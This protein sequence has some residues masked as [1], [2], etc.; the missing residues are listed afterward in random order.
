MNNYFI[1]HNEF[2]LESG[3]AL[4]GIKIAYT[5]SGNPFAK[6]TIWVC[7]ALSG[8]AEATQWWAGLFSDS[9]LF[10]LSKYRV[11]CANVLGS[12]YGSTGAG[13]LEEPLTFP[14]ITIRDMV[15]AHQLLAAYLNV[16]NVDVLIGASLGGQQALEWS[17]IDTEFADQLILVATNAVHSP[18]GIA[19]NESQRLALQADLTFGLK[20][21]G[22]AGLKAARAIAMLSYRSAND[23]TIKQSDSSRSAFSHRASSYVNYQG[24]KFIDRFNPYAYFYLSKAMDSHDVSRSRS[25]FSEVLSAVKAKTL[26][27]GVDSDLLFPLTEQ[28]FLA[29]HITGAELG[30]IKSPYGHDAFLIEFEQLNELIK[31]FLYNDFKR[32]RPTVL[33]TKQVNK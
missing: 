18:Y 1:H 30:V 21:G 28:K 23:F 29:D 2:Q 15:K 9:T 20:T 13:E 11:I 19:F 26:V 8:N 24:E 5:I 33:K 10:D 22:K 27:I 6:K 12:C 25:S 14:F 31:D 3:K 16:K 4:N 32:N 17:I 7:H